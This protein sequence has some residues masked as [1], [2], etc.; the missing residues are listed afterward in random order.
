VLV[1]KQFSHVSS[2]GVGFF[3]DIEMLRI[4]ERN[5]MFVVQKRY[6][7]FWWKDTF[8]E[9]RN[10]KRFKAEFKTIQ[11]AEALINAVTK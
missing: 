3:K 9:D 5:G 2:I 6:F 7:Y 1:A 11:Q 4:V 10:R 8:F